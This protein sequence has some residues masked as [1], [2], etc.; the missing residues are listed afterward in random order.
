LKSK[1]INLKKHSKNKTKGMIEMSFKINDWIIAKENVIEEFITVHSKTK[2]F[3]PG[4]KYLKNPVKITSLE[5]NARRR[6]L[7]KLGW[8]EVELK[9]GRKEEAFADNYRLATELE[10]KSKKIKDIFSQN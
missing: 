5:I 9:N 3:H 1:L 8:I 4:I 2:Y 10:I 7:K 6:G